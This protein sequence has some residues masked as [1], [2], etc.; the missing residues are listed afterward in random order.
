MS[1][2]VVANARA[3]QIVEPTDDHSFVLKI[4]ALETILNAE[5]IRDRHVVVV[6]VAGALRQGK[7][8]LLNFYLQYL[9]AQ[10][11]RKDASQFLGENLRKCF[12]WRSGCDIPDTIGILIWSEIFTHDSDDGEKLAIILMDTQGSFDSNSSVRD[13]STIFAMSAMLSSV[14]CY[15]LMNNIREDDLQYLHLFTEYGKLSLDESPEEKPF[16]V[17][18]FVVRDW[19]FAYQYKFGYVG[20]EGV[21]TKRLEKNNKQTEDMK[22]LR[23]QLKSSFEHI[24]G[25]LMPHPGDAVTQD[26][27][28]GGQ[29]SLIAAQFK[30][31]LQE[32]VPNILAPE[33]LI[34]K[35]ING[36]K[37]RAKDFIQYLKSYMAVFNGKDMPEPK[38]IFEATADSYNMIAFLDAK[39]NYVQLM[40]KSLKGTSSYFTNDELRKLHLQQK[41]LCIVQFNSKP[42]LGGATIAEKY[43]RKLQDEIEK[44]YNIQTV[45]N[46]AKKQKYI[47][48]QEVKI[49]KAK[50]EAVTSYKS[51]FEKELAG[52]A[53]YLS[54]NSMISHHAR[55]KKLAIDLFNSKLSKEDTEIAREI[56]KKLENE[57]E[58]AYLPFKSKNSEKEKAV[59]K[60]EKEKERLVKEQKEKELKA[61]EEALKEERRRRSQSF[62]DSGFYSPQRSYSPQSSYSCYSPTPQYYSTPISG[63]SS[64]ASSYCS[65]SPSASA[66]WSSG[67]NASLS[68]VFSNTGRDFARAAEIFNNSSACSTPKTAAQMRNKY[69]NSRYHKN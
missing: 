1:S 13:C 34:I 38:S 8:F 43:L 39:S 64:V 35:K 37:V 57:L 26:E 41:S 61:T 36:R 40:T 67:E 33:N 42:K 15:N 23:D 20:G 48:A 68:S 4:D 58:S 56:M 25:F 2:K 31:A 46:E 66:N 49:S 11:K 30:D 69:Y 55:I 47:K 65:S 63:R 5:S 52:T 17:L 44:E 45:L 53:S 9:N 21:V 32:L 50:D 27:N 54:E 51:M 6:S 12:S 29:I 16:Q 60:Q 19:Q 18:L 14:L 7:S 3:L 62:A 10:Y 59:L 28:Y 24:R 22:K